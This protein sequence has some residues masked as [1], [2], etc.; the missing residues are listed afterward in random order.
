[1]VCESMFSY[2]R[3]FAALVALSALAMAC[4]GA[5]EGSGE[6]G[7]GDG[8][9]DPGPTFGDDDPPQESEVVGSPNANPGPQFGV[10]GNESPSAN[11]PVNSNGSRGNTT[12]STGSGTSGTGTGTGSSTG[13]GGSGTGSIPSTPST[14]TSSDLARGPDPTAESVTR[15]GPFRVETYTTGLRNGSGYGTQTMHR[16]ADGEPPFAAVAIVP[17]FVSPESAIRAWG[18]FLAS[19]GIVTL[20]IGTN[21]PGDSPDI[22]ANALLDALETIKAENTRSG[23]PLEGDIAIDSLGVMG[24]SMGGGGTLI[25]AQ[26][27]PALKAAVSMAAWSPGVRFSTNTVPTLMLAGSADGLAGGQSQ[28]FFTSMPED[29]PKMLVEIRGGP[30]D[31]ANDP[32]NSGGTIGRFGLSWLEV[33]LVGDERYRQF[34]GEAPAQASDF[35]ENLTP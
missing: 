10:S 3:T 9:A 24:W 14:G 32:K 31:I 13:P 8:P 23:S 33:F 2:R 21:N 6:I 29:T 35:R 26:R 19:H 20:T 28:G 11:A 30:H 12:G 17:G 7:D 1:M 34:L 15:A 16:P 18:P 27:T 22:R 4:G 25:A 5:G